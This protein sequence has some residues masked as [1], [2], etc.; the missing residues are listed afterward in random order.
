MDSLDSP[1]QSDSTDD[2]LENFDMDLI[3]L[4]QLV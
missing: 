2:F 4:K 3:D 1:V